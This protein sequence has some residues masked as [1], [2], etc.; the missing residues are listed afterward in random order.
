MSTIQTRNNTFA[1]NATALQEVV[2]RQI[3]GWSVLYTK[4]HNF[5]WYVQGPHFFTLHAKFEE[6]GQFSYGEYGRSCRTFA[7]YWWTSGGYD[8]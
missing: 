5:H 1:N 4:L 8:G 3:A 7:G 2:N 6:P